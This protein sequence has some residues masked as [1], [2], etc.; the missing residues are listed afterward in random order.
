MR[1]ALLQGGELL[2]VVIGRIVEFLGVW[3][4]SFAGGDGFLQAGRDVQMLLL[5]FSSSRSPVSCSGFGGVLCPWR[6]QLGG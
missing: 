6:A 5:K 4:A 1:K 3:G 2:E